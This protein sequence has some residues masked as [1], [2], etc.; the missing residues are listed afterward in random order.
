MWSK[1]AR[2]VHLWH[3]A[4][5]K[6]ITQFQRK[7]MFPA[8]RQLESYWT[9]STGPRLNLIGWPWPILRSPKDRLSAQFAQ[10][11]CLAT[12]MHRISRGRGT[13]LG[14]PEAIDCI[15]HNQS[16]TQDRLSAQFALGGWFATS[17]LLV[18]AHPHPSR[19]GL[20]CCSCQGGHTFS[21]QVKQYCSF[22]FRA[23]E[24]CFACT[25]QDR[26]TLSSRPLWPS[27]RK[28]GKTETNFDEIQMKSRW[29]LGKI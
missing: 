16:I 20:G 9:T 19:W 1:I 22:A 18:Q 4:R 6:L 7:H 29:D 24:C 23:S 11:R 15:L 10:V 21:W 8:Q 26:T 28:A 3:T 13:A 5:P 14:S 27:R 17:W 12:P 2:R 25:W